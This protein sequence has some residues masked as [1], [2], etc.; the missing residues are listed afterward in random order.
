MIKISGRTFYVPEEHK[1]TLEGMGL[2]LNGTQPMCGGHKMAE[3]IQ[4]LL[5]DGTPRGEGNVVFCNA[6][7]RNVFR[8]YNLVRTDEKPAC[9][10]GRGT[11]L[12]TLFYRPRGGNVVY[13]ITANQKGAKYRGEMHSFT[14]NAKTKK[15]H[16][17]LVKS[18]IDTS[19]MVYVTAKDI[20]DMLCKEYDDYLD[21]YKK[22]MV[23]SEG[24]IDIL[25]SSM[26]MINDIVINA[27]NREGLLEAC[28]KEQGWLHYA[29]GGG[30]RVL[31]PYTGPGIDYDFCSFYPSI[32][33]SNE[34]PAGKATFSAQ[35]RFLDLSVLALYKCTMEGPGHELFKKPKPGADQERFYTNID[36]RAALSMGVDIRLCPDENTVTWESVCYGADVFG[37]TIKALYSARAQGAELA[38]KFVN[39]MTGACAEGNWVELKPDMEYVTIKNSLFDD[40]FIVLPKTQVY[41]RPAICRFPVF[42]TAYGRDRL[43][44]EILPRME[45]VV[46]AHTDSLVVSK[47]IPGL[48]QEVSAM[49]AIV[50][51]HRGQVTTGKKCIWTD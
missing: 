37:D 46:Y 25:D 11:E 7:M 23:S 4:E 24:R 20:H 42:M 49:G 41:K 48:A 50:I 3:V 51:K 45:D 14:W 10:K 34:F 5:E 15:E 16:K 28:P 9:Q 26:P 27:L 39:N 6:S 8:W 40:G 32:L 13:Y 19:K 47:E 18:L 43:R 35:E 30:L 36:V 33:M 2:S 12:F 29:Y 38:K 1:E 17:P 31:K 44:K 21:A 22:I